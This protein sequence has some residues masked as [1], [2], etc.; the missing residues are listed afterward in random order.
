MLNQET[1]IRGHVVTG[2]GRSLEPYRSGRATVAQDLAALR[3]LA[4]Q[5]PEIAGDVAASGTAEADALDRSL[6][7][8]APVLPLIEQT[9]TADGGGAILPV[10]PERGRAL[11]R[12]AG[13]PLPRRARARPAGRHRRARARAH[14]QRL[15]RDRLAKRMGGRLASRRGQGSTFTIQLPR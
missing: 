14:A 3:A 11:A 1:G 15:P 5:R 4:R 2:D 6:G 12:R 10:R 8:I 9:L 7:D 13:D